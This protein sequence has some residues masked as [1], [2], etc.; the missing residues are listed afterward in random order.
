MHP[1]THT[2][3]THASPQCVQAGQITFEDF[4]MSDMNIMPMTIVGYEGLFGMGM[5]LCI[6]M[7]IAYFLP[8]QEGEGLHEN[9]L[10]TFWVCVWV[11]VGVYNFGCEG[12]A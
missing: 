4:F 6:M 1:P 2:S 7:P 9:T 5:M 11:C 8:G 10:H 12:H 3:N